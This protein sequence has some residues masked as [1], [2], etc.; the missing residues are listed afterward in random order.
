MQI[1]NSISELTAKI[2]DVLE[3]NFDAISVV[4]EISNFHAHVSGHWYFT[5][6]DADAQISCV[7]WRGFNNQVFFTPEDGMKV[8]VNG[9]LNVYPPRGNYQ[10]DVRSMKPAGVGELQAA[11]ERL[12]RKLADEGLF[13]DL[14]KKPLPKIP[15]KIGIVTARGGAALRDMINIASRRYPLV[16]LVIANATVQGKEAAPEIVSAIKRLNERDDIDLIIVGRGGGSLEDLWAFNEEIVA[17]AI[18]DSGIPIVSGVGHEVDYTI[19]DFVADL[20]APTPSAAIELSTPNKEDILNVLIEYEK[21]LTKI[22]NDKLFEAHQSVQRL[23]KS[24]GFRRPKDRILTHIQTI[25]NISYRI[26]DK[27]MQNMERKMNKVNLLRKSLESN[28]VEKSLKKG[29]TLIKQN[30]KFVTRSNFLN[31]DNEIK[32]KFYDNEIS[33]NKN[34]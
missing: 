4:G 22:L 10:I 21:D 18:Y 14:H 8:I 6:K 3:F 20:R 26:Q 15:N 19:S 17:R 24:Y 31:L 25:D 7:M 13:E 16:E 1:Y 23:L 29:F 30:G 28:D 12:K 34:G 32:I 2:K 9:K 27:M 33:V 11:F 5:L